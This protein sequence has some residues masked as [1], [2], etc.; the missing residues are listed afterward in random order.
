MKQFKKSREPT[1][2]KTNVVS[3]KT[4]N[5]VSLIK[6]NQIVSIHNYNETDIMSV[7]RFTIFRLQQNEKWNF[8]LDI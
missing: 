1:S 3:I 5:K 8:F 2:F 4:F 7:Y 6:R